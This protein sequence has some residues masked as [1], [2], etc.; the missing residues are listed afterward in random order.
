MSTTEI[1]AP[2]TEPVGHPPGRSRW[3][4]VGAWLLAGLLPVATILIWLNGRPPAVF[5][6][7]DARTAAAGPPA[8]TV[9]P[10]TVR[11]VT[12]AMLMPT[13]GVE[14]RWTQGLDRYLEQVREDETL[15]CTRARQIPAP[16]TPPP[17]F[18]RFPF[19]PD[20]QRIDH[21][22]FEV[23]MGGAP[24]GGKVEPAVQQAQQS[25]LQSASALVRPVQATY[26]TLQSQWFT[27]V[28]ALRNGPSGGPEIAAARTD[29]AR[30]LT[31]RGIPVKDEN[32]LFN[33]VDS[34]VAGAG[35]AAEENRRDQAAGRAY[36]ACAGPLE[37]LVT[38]KRQALRKQFLTAHD[39]EIRE[40]RDHLIEALRR[41]AQ[42]TPAK[43]VFPVP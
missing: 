36:A 9:P 16:A 26:M 41:L 21:H 39:D 29:V 18:H 24:P 8:A 25:C 22:G 19:L 23:V 4:L 2:T 10:Q 1:Q 17:S 40:V 34:Q 27:A 37:A 5:S 3:R 11:A 31:A 6:D 7:Q 14:A 28:N 30:C 43:M 42:T 32:G 38:P 13:T 12:V 20:L 15:R 33:Y 35:S